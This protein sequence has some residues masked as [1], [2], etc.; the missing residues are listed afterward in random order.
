MNKSPA[1]PWLL[2]IFCDMEDRI[3]DWR[4]KINTRGVIYDPSSPHNP[5]MAVWCRTLRVLI[6]HCPAVYHFVD[7]GSGKGK[8]CACA[9]ST[10]RF[11]RVIGVEFDHKLITANKIEGVEFYCC[12]ALEYELPKERSMVFLF[13]TFK[14]EAMRKFIEKNLQS[15]KDNGHVLA[16]AND[17]H[18]GLLPNYGFTEIYRDPLHKI[19]LWRHNLAIKNLQ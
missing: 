10:G 12:D 15:F 11:Y 19:S 6:K 4:H 2:R 16:Y 8:A 9:K 14:E 17:V 5:Y 18:Y 1:Y 13:N 3:F 7:I